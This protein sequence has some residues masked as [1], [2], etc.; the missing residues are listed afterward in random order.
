MSV[1]F[2]RYEGVPGTGLDFGYHGHGYQP[3]DSYHGR[4][5]GRYGGRY[6]DRYGY[7][8]RRGYGGYGG[9]YGY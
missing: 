9:R 5:D 1:H 4:F 6:G 7:D 2:C 3:Y 8:G